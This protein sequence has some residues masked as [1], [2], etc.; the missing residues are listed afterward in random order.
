MFEFI[1]ILVIAVALV[2]FGICIYKNNQSKIDADETKVETV[3][4]E[5]K[6]VVDDDVKK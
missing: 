4:D 5:V 3:V 1:V 6:T 2:A